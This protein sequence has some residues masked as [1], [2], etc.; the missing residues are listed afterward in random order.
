MNNINWPP[1]Q[2]DASV[3]PAD[4]AP[5]GQS[6]VTICKKRHKQKKAQ[7]AKQAWKVNSK[8]KDIDMAILW[9]SFRAAH[10]DFS[11]ATRMITADN[12]LFSL[13][14]Y[15]S[16]DDVDKKWVVFLR[17]R[18]REWKVAFKTW[19]REENELSFDL[20]TWILFICAV[21]DILWVR[22]ELR[23]WFEVSEG[24]KV[25]KVSLSRRVV[26]EISKILKTLKFLD[27]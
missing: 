10:H 9:R 8:H 22:T 3:G 13:S 2:S 6:H 1:P 19:R 23:T 7:W 27:N 16:S 12:V 18:L 24:L 11:V 5:T 21:F 26:N 4:A 15:W 25:E 17:R 20:Q 14:L